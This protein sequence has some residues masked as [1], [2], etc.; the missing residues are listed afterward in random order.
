MNLDLSGKTAVVCGST[1][2]L[3][4]ASAVELALLGCNVVLLAR[5]EEKLKPVTASLQKNDKQQHSWLTA[6]FDDS[7]I[8]G[9]VIISFVKTNT[10]HILVN[11]TGGP[12]P[13]TVM[14]ADSAAFFRHLIITLLIT[15]I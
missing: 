8:V 3:G 15:T 2:E 4:Y 1:P 14:A 7:E 13:G 9:N 10:V 11:N 6:N 12:Q 5:N